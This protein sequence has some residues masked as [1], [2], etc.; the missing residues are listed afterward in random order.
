LQFGEINVELI[1]L[2]QDLLPATL[3]E[4]VEFGGELGHAVAQVLEA[5]VDAGE[6]VGH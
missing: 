2:L 1:S 3:D 5:E 4:G 6:R